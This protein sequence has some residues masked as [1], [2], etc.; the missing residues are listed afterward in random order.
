MRTWGTAPPAAARACSISVWPGKRGPLRR[1]PACAPARSPRAAAPAERQAGR[2]L[3]AGRGARP[4]SACTWP[5]GRAARRPAARRLPHRDAARRG[6]A[7]ARL[8]QRG[9]RPMQGARG[10]GAPHH[11]DIAHHHARRRPRPHEALGDHF[12]P[13]AAR[14]AHRQREQRRAHH[15]HHAGFG[16]S[17]KRCSR[18]KPTPG[19]APTPAPGALGRMVAAGDEGDTRLAREVG[20][21]LGDLAGQKGID[22]SRDGRLEVPWAPPVHQPMRRTRG[23]RL[24]PR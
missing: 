22:T 17:M 14:V 1:A 6:G 16:T 7:P 3:D 11:R 23:R 2:G 19:A 24:P 20:L 12:G 18:P 8:V 4:A 15:R 13:D 5:I 9:N 21:R 10:H